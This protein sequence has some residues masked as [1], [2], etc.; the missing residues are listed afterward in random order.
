MERWIDLDEENEQ[1]DV[2]TYELELQGIEAMQR[3]A[4]A[5]EA[6]TRALEKRNADG[7]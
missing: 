6:L 3:L 4:Y 5:I 7:E 2:D 1:P